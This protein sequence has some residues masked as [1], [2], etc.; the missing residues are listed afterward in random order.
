MVSSF[1]LLV[2]V[3]VAATGQFAFESVKCLICS[4]IQNDYTFDSFAFVFV[5]PKTNVANYRVLS[6]SSFKQ[7]VKSIVIGQYVEKS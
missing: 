7:F 5:L 4:C 1:I 6:F 3:F 2:V